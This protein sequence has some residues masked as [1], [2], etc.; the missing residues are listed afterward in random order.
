MQGCC[1]KMGDGRFINMWEDLW[2]HYQ[3]WFKAL[4]WKPSN[5][6]VLWARKLI[7]KGSNKWNL[8]LNNEILNSYDKHRI[9]EFCF[10]TSDV[11]SFFLLLFLM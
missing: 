2:F 11:V 7:D 10:L 9:I 6:K 4:S 3:S 8:T 5:F 1:W